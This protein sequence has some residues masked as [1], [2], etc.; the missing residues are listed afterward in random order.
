MAVIISISNGRA[1]R[2]FYNPDTRRKY[3]KEFHFEA[4][5][6]IELETESE[7]D[8]A[9]NMAATYPT[10][11]FLNEKEY[12]NYL[13]SVAEEEIEEDPVIGIVEPVGGL[14]K[15]E[16]LEAKSLEELRQLALEVGIGTTPTM[17]RKHIA[18][19]ILKQ[20]EEN[21]AELNDIT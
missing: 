19:R 2:Q 17:N 4:G 15:I 9:K 5:V 1:D 13:A 14:P 11:Y 20:L 18:K 10:K 8:W 12:E 7:I 21:K 6:P 3:K 16:E